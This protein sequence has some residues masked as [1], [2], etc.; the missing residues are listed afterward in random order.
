MSIKALLAG[1]ALLLCAGTAAAFEI[2]E[3]ALNDYLAQGLARKAT[4]DVQLVN[5]HVTLLDGYA[6]LCAGVGSPLLAKPVDVCADVTPVWRPESGSLLA[7][8]MALVSLDAPG[9][10]DKDVELVKTLV[11][12]LILPGLEGVEVYRADS[13]IGQQVASMKVLPGRLELGF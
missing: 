9:V 8:R 4:R 12:Q 11:N 13:F 3:G 1:A 10:R 5:P 7:T 2:S 6:R